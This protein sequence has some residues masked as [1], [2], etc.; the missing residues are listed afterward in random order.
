MERRSDNE[1]LDCATVFLR[2][3]AKAP[4]RSRVIEHG[5][6]LLKKRFVRLTI[7]NET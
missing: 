3:N 2:R 5:H 4:D 6:V 1:L 7:P